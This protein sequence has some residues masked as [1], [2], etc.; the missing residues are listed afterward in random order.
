M[1]DTSSA[2]WVEDRKADLD[3]QRVGDRKVGINQRDRRDDDDDDCEPGDRGFPFFCDRDRDDDDDDEEID[4]EAESGDIEIE[5]D[6]SLSGD[7]S[8]QCVAVLQ[9]GNTGNNQNAQGFGSPFFD[10]FDGDRF[11]DFF[12]F[13]GDRFRDFEDFEAEGGFI[14]F[15]PEFENECEQTIQ[16]AAVAQGP[17]A[18]R[19]RAVAPQPVVGRAARPVVAGARGAIISPSRAVP[20]RLGQATTTGRLTGRLPRTGGIG[21]ASLP[22]LGIGALLI[23][24][25]LLVRRLS[26]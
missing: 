9:F 10:D 23:G 13:D 3:E 18:A 2:E 21:T 12:D 15:E 5:T 19:A 8:N 20:A 11:R 7:N 17:F 22:M 4:Q 1:I 25:G 16:Q 24:G 26:R 14:A 6:I